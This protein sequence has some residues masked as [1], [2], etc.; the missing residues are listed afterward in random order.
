MC[1]SEDI[2]TWPFTTKT[3]NL[4]TKD[5]RRM[6]TDLQRRNKQ[7]ATPVPIH[8]GDDSR[9]LVR[10]PGQLAR[11]VESVRVL[12]HATVLVTKLEESRRKAERDSA[13]GWH[14]PDV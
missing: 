5:T 4:C 10:Q 14:I 1:Q 12:V 3:I 6:G 9:A 11:L 8:G 13:L 2:G 7:V